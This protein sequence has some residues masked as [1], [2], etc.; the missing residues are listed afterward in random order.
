MSTE[1]K[2]LNV[3][4]SCIGL[5]EQYTKPH[6]F[7]V[8]V[9][10]IMV[11]LLISTAIINMLS[12]FWLL[13]LVIII[14]VGL[15]EIVYAVRISFDLALLR[16]L[17]V[18]TGSI[19]SRL[20]TIDDSLRILHLLPSYKMGRSLNIRL[21]GCV[22]LLKTQMVLCVVQVIAVIAA[23]ALHLMLG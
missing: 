19:D 21:I 5:I 6:L 2:N 15:M 23:P 17:A 14:V 10:L 8:G 11:V 7:S 9:T 1:Y 12:V 4:F 20:T 18:N 22:R 13:V 3:I 16:R